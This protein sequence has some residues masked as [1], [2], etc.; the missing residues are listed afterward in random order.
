MNIER[1]LEQAIAD[2]LGI[3][4]QVDKIKHNL[5]ITTDRPAKLE[6][7]KFYMER[8]CAWVEVKSFAEAGLYSSVYNINLALMPVL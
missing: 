1:T 7:I 3:I 8:T 4:A 6:K 2:D 5:M